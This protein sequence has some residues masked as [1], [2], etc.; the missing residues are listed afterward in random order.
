V[1]MAAITGTMVDS[2]RAHGASEPA[3]PTISS[4]SSR[5]ESS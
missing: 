1:S 4:R 5:W 2:S 3:A